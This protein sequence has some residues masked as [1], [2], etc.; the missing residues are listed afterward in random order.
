MRQEVQDSNLRPESERSGISPRRWD[1]IAGP[2]AVLV[3]GGVVT[4]CSL[5]ADRTAEPHAQPAPGGS[6]TKPGHPVL[7]SHFRGWPA[8]KKPDVALMLTGQQHSYLK[9]CGCSQP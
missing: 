4:S 6:G 2:F 7:D 9:F 1:V 3:V 5:R 8:G